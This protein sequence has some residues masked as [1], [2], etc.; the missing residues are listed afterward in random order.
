MAAGRL[1]DLYA[2]DGKQQLTK[3]LF[4]A[5]LFTKEELLQELTDLNQGLELS[6]VV[7]PVIAPGTLRTEELSARSNLY[8]EFIRNSRAIFL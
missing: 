4:A 5:V 7:D 2:N 3:E 1:G 6:S 8:R